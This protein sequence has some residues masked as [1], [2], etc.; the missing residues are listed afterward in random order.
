MVYFVKVVLLY[1]CILFIVLIMF[2]AVY[3]KITVKLITFLNNLV[4]IKAVSNPYLQLTFYNSYILYR[5][6]NLLTRICCKT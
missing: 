1:Q 2:F 5:T 3:Y 6:M 4:K